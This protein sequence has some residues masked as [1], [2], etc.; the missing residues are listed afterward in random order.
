M[1]EYFKNEDMRRRLVQNCYDEVPRFGV[2]AFLEKWM[3]LMATMYE[4]VQLR[5]N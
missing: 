5:M 2:E 3:A 1:I 4:R